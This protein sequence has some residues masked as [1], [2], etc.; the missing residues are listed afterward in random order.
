MFLKTLWA[1]GIMTPVLHLL[2]G[3]VSLHESKAVLDD[4]RAILLFKQVTKLNMLNDLDI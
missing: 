3:Y 2:A 1:L 4:L